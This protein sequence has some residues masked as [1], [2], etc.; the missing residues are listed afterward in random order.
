VIGV[1]EKQ[2][3]WWKGELNGKVGYFP[4]NYVRAAVSINTIE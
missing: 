4:A 3:E 1:L 2:G